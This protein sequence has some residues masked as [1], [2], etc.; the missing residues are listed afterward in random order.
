MQGAMAG[1]SPLRPRAALRLAPKIVL[2]TWHRNPQA[3][4]PGGFVCRVQPHVVLAKILSMEGAVLAQCQHCKAH[5]AITPCG[6]S[7]GLA[8]RPTQQGSRVD[9]SF[10]I[11]EEQ[12]ETRHHLPAGAFAVPRQPL[13]PWAHVVDLALSRT[14]DHA[15]GVP[16]VG[17]MD[18]SFVLLQQ[19]PARPPPGSQSAAA[20]PRS[21]W[22]TLSRVFELASEAALVDQP[23]CSDCAKD[24][25]QELEA[26]LEEVR[27]EVAAYEAL[28][29]KLQAE[30]AAAPAPDARELSR[31]LRRA[32]DEASAEE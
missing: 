29:V 11:L 25:Q 9:E 30:E 4:V 8:G 21:S 22:Q 13:A 32:Q 3:P 2:L 5:L 12:L 17:D 14:P 26:Q 16:S 23:L 27:G 6:D 19:A 10:L 28:E 18:E 15:S 7:S 20:G 24:V 31:Q 1:F